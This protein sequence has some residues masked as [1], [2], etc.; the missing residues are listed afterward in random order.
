MTVEVEQVVDL[1]EVKDSVR[2]IACKMSSKAINDKINDLL[3]SINQSEE[4]DELLM[5]EAQCYA[6]IY[7]RRSGVKTRDNT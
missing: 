7:L 3:E 6:N 5:M 2:Q 4:P 1:K